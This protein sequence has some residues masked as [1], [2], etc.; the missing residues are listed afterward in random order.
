MASIMSI[1]WIGF[2]ALSPGLRTPAGVALRPSDWTDLGS[3]RGV[4][5]IM[6]ISWIGF[7]ALSKRPA[8]EP[9]QA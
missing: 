1:S 3:P 5:S 6:S 2:I 8:L 7:R 9:Q 4:A